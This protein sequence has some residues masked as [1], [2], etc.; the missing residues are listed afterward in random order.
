MLLHELA[1]LGHERLVPAERELGVDPILERLEPELLEP[2]D[3][4]A[5]ERLVGQVGERTAPPERQRRPQ[6]IRRCADV[7]VFEQPAAFTG[8]AL[9]P[10]GIELIR[11]NVQYVSGRPRDE[12]LVLAP[13][14]FRLQRFPKA[15]DVPLE[16]V[17]R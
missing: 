12:S 15:R 16:H 8:Q 2:V 5:R 4:R 17:R 7:A 6:P 10:L 14:V 9:E 13:S 1:Q 11:A 3:V